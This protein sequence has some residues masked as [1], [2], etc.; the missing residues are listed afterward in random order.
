MVGFVRRRIRSD[1]IRTCVIQRLQEEHIPCRED[2]GPGL[3]L[4]PSC[5]LMTDQTW[6]GTFKGAGGGTLGSDHGK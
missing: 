6:S 1:L 4:P 3:S 5:L 2:S